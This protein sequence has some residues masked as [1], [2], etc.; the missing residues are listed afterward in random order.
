[1]AAAPC[2]E[3]RSR[4]TWVRSYSGT[5]IL[6]GMTPADSAEHGSGAA[7]AGSGR[8]TAP[9]DVSTA[10]DL[11]IALRNLLQSSYHLV[12]EADS[13]ALAAAKIGAHGRR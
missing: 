8:E 10:T 7:A 11:A 3:W 5:A 12:T 13:A 2:S 6:V 9:F 1:M 4:K